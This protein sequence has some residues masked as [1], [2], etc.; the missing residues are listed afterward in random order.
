MSPTERASRPTNPDTL[1][2]L[3]QEIVET[4][5]EVAEIRGHC[6]R[7]DAAL[8]APAE[9][10]RPGTFAGDPPIKGRDATGLCATIARLAYDNEVTQAALL[11]E[12]KRRTNEAK[13]RTKITW[14]AG[15]ISIVITAL[16]QFLLA[17]HSWVPT[18]PAAPSA[19]HVG[20]KP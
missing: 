18:P 5:S 4:R 10:P 13:R 1:L 12:S 17:A 9:P 2:S 16:S 15:G 6:V 7:M 20:E 14:S 8:G 19:A 3:S 11:A